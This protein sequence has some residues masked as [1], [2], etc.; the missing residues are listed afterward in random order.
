LDQIDYPAR[1]VWEPRQKFFDDIFDFE[2]RGGAYVIGEQASG[3]LIDLQAIYCVGAFISVIII[4]CTVVDAHL[5]EAELDP[6]FKG[7]IAKAFE[8]SEYSVD[9]D[10]LR[11]R[12]NELV[13][14]TDRRPLPISVDEQWS[15]RQTHEAEANRAIQLVANVLFENPWV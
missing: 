1:S 3:L 4:A 13:H 14:F 7:G 15:N 10:W 9:L 12:R 6:K 5:R 11:R 2:P 8:T